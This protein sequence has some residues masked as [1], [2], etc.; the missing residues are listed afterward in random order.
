MNEL[1]ELV[2]RGVL[3]GVA[4]SAAMHAWSLLLRRGFG[5][6]TL[7]YALLGRWIGHMP[8]GRFVHGRIAAS[9]ITMRSTWAEGRGAAPLAIEPGLSLERPTLQSRHQPRHSVVS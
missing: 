4:G 6:P 2:A 8:R 3:M 5:I 7:D 9:T 1:L